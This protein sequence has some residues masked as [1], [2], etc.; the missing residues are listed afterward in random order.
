MVA[1]DGHRL[2]YV[3]TGAG[4]AARWITNFPRAGSQEGHG[5]AVKLADGAD[6]ENAKANFRG[7]TTICFS[8]WETGC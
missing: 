1:T 7:T 4:E 2:A 3:Q 6:G 5:R 8:K